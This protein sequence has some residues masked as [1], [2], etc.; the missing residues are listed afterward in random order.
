MSRGDDGLS[1]RGRR[2]ALRVTFGGITDIP[3]SARCRTVTGL[4]RR[5]A[6]ER[7]G[8]GRGIEEGQP[9]S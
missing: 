5:P 7:Y 8:G 2:T 9:W 6:P 1:L 4:E 3:G